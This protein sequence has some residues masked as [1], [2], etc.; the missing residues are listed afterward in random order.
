[1]NKQTL[2]TS[3][4][5]LY[6]RLIALWV[7]NEAMIGGI[8]HGLHL[9]VSGLLVG[10]G[11]VVCISLIAWYVPQKGAILK[12]T[13][14]VAIFKM[15]LSPHAPLPAYFAV[16][17]QGALGELLFHRRRFFRV[18]CIALGMLALL[19]SGVQRILVL[20]IIYG[21]GFWQVVNDFFNR[22]TGQH[23][24]T[25]YSFFIIACYVMFHAFAG[26]LVGIWVGAI[27]MRIK[28][29]HPLRE[30]YVVKLSGEDGLVLGRRKRKKTGKKI[31]LV[32]WILLL[33]LWAQSEFHW[34]DPWLPA[35]LALHIL[36]R[37]FIIVLAWI[38]VI[39]PIL[40]SLLNKWLQKKQSAAAT[41]VK[42]VLDILPQTQNL[43]TSAWKLSEVKKG[44]ARI[45]LWVRI[46]LAYTFTGLDAI[47]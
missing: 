19:E 12:A 41:D 36:I 8:I 35:S 23:E 21:N 20:T 7:L 26:C 44:F 11:A 33:A 28:L 46:V 42:A 24:L 37:S 10:S 34:G 3:S 1:M 29:M 40:T 47:N 5:S 39:G 25:D 18:A 13:I 38:F 43:I 31:L 9:P 30:E 15:M 6:Y 4:A 22:L 16:F 14:I 27:P 2:P 45:K 17:F 32:C